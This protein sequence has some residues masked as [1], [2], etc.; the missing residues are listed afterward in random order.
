MTEFDFEF[1]FAELETGSPSE[2]SAPAEAEPKSAEPTENTRLL[3]VHAIGQYVFCP[4][5]AVL[6]LETGDQTDID[7]PP[8]RLDFLPN[9][10]LERIEEE[11]SKQLRRLWPLLLLTLAAIAPMVVGVWRQER[12]VF[13]PALAI[14]LTCA[15]GV[16]AVSQA[17]LVLA[18]RRR[19]AL[20]AQ[21]RE[22]SPHIEQVEPVNWWCM[23]KARFD[24]I[25]YGRPVR[26][27][28]L[29]L[30]GN[31]W[32]VLER[33]SMRIP[34]VRS[35][36]DKLG[37]KPNQVYEKHT[38]RLAAYA[39]L[40]ETTKHVESPYGLVFP[41]DSHVGLAVPLPKRKKE[42]VAELVEQLRQT[43]RQSQAG[44][45]EPRPPKN[46]KLCANCPHGRPVPI[47][48]TEAKK[49]RAA[50]SL[51]VFEDPRE[52]MFHCVCGDRFGSAPP[53]TTS[54]RRG[55]VARVQ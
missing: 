1:D 41:V 10:D 19:A 32:R 43:L 51:L 48:E 28:L 50:G 35:G 53:H 12:L 6:A 39:A 46:D 33:A 14:F 5:S 20:R 3:S 49:L 15:L 29:P 13:Y 30:E 31:P 36:G 34:V 11:L 2:E 52:K 21:A 40:L 18:A 55:L 38:L 42:A 27:P 7:E 22:P 23:L 8:P 45:S 44:Q 37:P 16:F 24:P 25:S 9:F 17:I 26:H 4:R 47:T 54:V